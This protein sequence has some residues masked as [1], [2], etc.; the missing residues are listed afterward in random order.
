MKRKK[1]MKR[2][3]EQKR[4]ADRLWVGSIIAA[5]LVAGIL[6]FVMLQMEKNMLSEYE[7][8]PVYVVAKTIPKGKLLTQ[9]NLAQY[10]I[11]EE[12][13]KRLVPETAI[14]DS[15][16]IQELI[17]IAELEQGVML[18]TGMFRAVNEI[19]ADMKEPVIAGFKAEDLYQVAG[20]VLRAGDRINI[21]SVNE[22]GDTP[23]VWEGLYIQ[24]VFDLSGN[25]IA[26]E[27]RTSASQRINIYLD[28]EN[29]EAFYSSLSQGTLRVVKI[30]D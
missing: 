10:L 1:G 23:I 19:T 21:Y 5:L 30:Y 8:A 22:E 28:E 2:E 25:A 6:F 11:Q 16:Q 27:D 14:Q 3:G 24:S 7:K 13:E 29:V 18:T 4:S 26:N 20:G 12:M 9:E 15:T 17:A